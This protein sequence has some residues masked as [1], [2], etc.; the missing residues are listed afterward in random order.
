MCSSIVNEFY[1]WSY[2]CHRRK[3][4]KMVK[5]KKKKKNFF[6]PW[7]YLLLIC[8]CVCKIYYKF[9]LYMHIN[10]KKYKNYMHT[11]LPWWLKWLRIHLPMEETRHWFDIRVQKIPWRRVWQSTPILLPGECTDREAWWVTIHGVTKSW[12]QLKWLSMH[13]YA[14][15][16]KCNKHK[17]EPEVTHYIT[18]QR[19]FWLI[20]EVWC[21][22]INFLQNQDCDSYIGLLLPHF[23]PYPLPQV[24]T[25][26]SKP[27]FSVTPSMSGSVSLVISL[28]FNVR[29][30][31]G[32]KNLGAQK[33]ALWSC[34]GS[35]T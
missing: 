30:K 32:S 14:C 28:L 35:A 12:V 7:D 25:C 10:F 15:Y 27:R 20:H 3:E 17:E 2:C 18:R 26:S 9:K 5:K 4:E 8:V 6:F 19:E 13:A 24:F 34:L 16:K 31:S 29:G 22:Y 23:I 1:C 33:E 21:I 11:G